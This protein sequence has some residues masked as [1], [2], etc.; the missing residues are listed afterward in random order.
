MT[1]STLHPALSADTDCLVCDD[2]RCATVLAADV[3]M[4]D[5]CGGTRLARLKDL[6]SVLCAWADT[7]PVA[8]QVWPGRRTVI[9]RSTG[10]TLVD[11]DLSRLPG[12]RA[13]HRQHALI[14]GQAGEWRVTQL[15]VNPLVVN[16]HEAVPT[17]E[18]RPIRPGDTLAV[19]GVQLQ[20]VVR[21][22][23]RTG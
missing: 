2:P 8:F 16:G 15:G 12:S 11:V 17:G 7:R 6:P 20:L 14:E 13:V 3:E 1:E 21:A 19:A 18:T 9:G 5:E 23:Q 10:S 22:S 4:C